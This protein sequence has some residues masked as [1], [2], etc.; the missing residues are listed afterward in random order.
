MLS[1]LSPL[2]PEAVQVPYSDVCANTTAILCLL[3]TKE[4]LTCAPWA[5]EK[6]MEAL[7]HAVLVFGTRR[8]VDLCTCIKF[9]KC[10]S[11]CRGLKTWLCQPEPGNIS[12]H[13]GR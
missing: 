8:C 7:D 1:L 2:G 3:L 5:V 10:S 13:G 6:P 4:S 9:F 12:F 11:E